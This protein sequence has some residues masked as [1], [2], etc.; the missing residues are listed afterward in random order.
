MVMYVLHFMYLT[1]PY[2]WNVG[3]VCLTFPALCDSIVHDVC[4]CVYIYIYLCI[5]ARMCVGDCALCT[6]DSHGYMN[7]PL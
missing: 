3:N 2:P 6:M 7:D 5:Y 4:V 1:G